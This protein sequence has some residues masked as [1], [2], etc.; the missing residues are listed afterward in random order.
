MEI[1]PVK[2][3]IKCDAQGCKHVADYVIQGKKGIIA[4]NMYFCKS[5]LE[6]LY[7]T[8]GSVI[9]PKSPKNKFKKDGE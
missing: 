1:R 8:I 6:E 2:I 7:K 4:S 5:C 3:E 9:V